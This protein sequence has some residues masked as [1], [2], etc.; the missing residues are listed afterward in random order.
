MKNNTPG[1]LDVVAKPFAAAGS[2]LPLHGGLLS[3][4]LRRTLMLGCMTML[5]SMA[6]LGCTV[7]RGTPNGTALG[8]VAGGQESGGG[9]NMAGTSNTTT[10]GNM[11]GTGTGT[12]AN[13]TSGQGTGTGMGV[14]NTGT[15]TTGD[16]NQNTGTGMQAGGGA[17]SSGTTGTGT[18]T[19]DPATSG[20]PVSCSNTDTSTIPIDETGWVAREC[21]DYGIQGAFYCF[22]DGINPSGCVA[23]TPPWG[24]DGMCLMGNTTEDDTF[25]AW[26]A[27]IG[28]SLNDLGEDMGKQAF[29]A[30]AA[31]IVGFSVS[32]TGDT[33]G[34]PVRIGFTASE[35]SDGVA[36]FVEVPG[37]GNYDVMLADALV[38]EAWDACTG[39]AC[40]V[41]P[42]SIYDM[43][44]QVVGGNDAADYQ[45]CVT[46]ITP[47]TDGSTPMQA[48]GA[49]A[50]YGSQVCGSFDTIN[51]GP[52]TVQNNAYNTGSHCIQALWD[53]GDI[54]GF[55][56]TN[57]SANVEAGGA[58]ASYPSLVYGWHVDGKFYGAYQS[59]KQ[60][61]AIGSI[62][63]EMTFTVPGSGRYNVSY[64]SWI[65]A[66]PSAGSDSQTKLEHMI[67]LNYR[68]TTP[69]GSPV[70]VV[71]IAGQ[72]W[73]VWYGPNSG[74]NTVS[75]IR[76]TNTT[77]ATID[78]NDF[79]QDSISRGYAA[80]SD[81]LLGVQAGFEIW[82]GSEDFSVDHFTVS[83]N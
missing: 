1:F 54:G 33:G 44:I 10:T 21:N 82:E 69:I 14:S 11:T 35:S 70:D 57:V 81:Y 60:L 17:A 39:D 36:P 6:M 68:D 19:T 42:S 9:A 72:S 63:S 26:G 59:P 5:G 38:P 31:G 49:V 28:F 83:V 65:A 32:I 53:N 47:I 16:P 79:M 45:F 61:S 20:G 62:P 80:G 77:S 23:D 12:T 52:Y 55:K 37:A 22:D 56:L 73:D 24:G 75:Y 34:L 51:I 71:M 8:G 40:F 18:G 41:D 4:T 64:D 15:T 78:L 29:D 67:W 3:R 13:N 46:N 76:A 43:Q 48:T 74:W 58:P 2:P 7:R 30:S 25:A 50:A 27:G 66:S